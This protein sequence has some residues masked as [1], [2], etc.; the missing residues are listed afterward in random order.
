MRKTNISLITLATTSAV[1]V[2]VLIIGIL[3]GS[4]FAAPAIN[5]NAQAS[6]LPQTTSETD[7][8]AALEEAFVDV[9]DGALPS[10]VNIRVMKSF[11]IGDFSDEDLPEEHPEFFNQGGGSGFVWDNQGHIVTNDHV[12]SGATDIEVLFADDTRAAAEIVGTDPDSDLAVIKVDL[13]AS[14]LQPLTLGD[15][16]QMRVGQLAIAIGSP[17]G[18]EFTMTSGI[19]SAVG[20]LIRGGNAGFSIP[21]AIQTDAPI[22]PGNSGGPLLNRSGEVIGINAQMASRTGASSG[23]GFAIPVNIAKKVVPALISGDDYK[24]AWLGISGGEVSVEMSDFRDLA[25]ATRGAVVI[26]VV[27]D[28]PAAAAG[29]QGRDASLDE[30]SDEYRFGGDIITAIDGQPVAGIDDLISY[31]VTLYQPGDTVTLDVIRANGSTEQLQV[32]L[33]ERPERAN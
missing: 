30:E 29:L 22:N 18:Q 26:E 33:G 16:D 1:V 24:Y 7:L 14:A 9:Y 2:V 32:T 23:I 25:D 4:V 10:V 6:T 17:F 8:V 28:G 19:V 12:V 13:P 15:S 5:S 27:D 20:R 21:T 31:L 11:D 3:L